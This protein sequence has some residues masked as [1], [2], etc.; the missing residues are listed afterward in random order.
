M[1]QNTLY[2]IFLKLDRLRVLIVGAGEVGYEKLSFMLKSSPDAQITV[3]AKEVL[4]PVQQL[5][6]ELQPEGLTVIEKPFEAEDVQGYGLVIAA[7]NFRALNEQVRAA[8]KANGALVN[9]ADTPELCDFYLGSIVTR[10][11]LKVAIST[12]GQSPTFAKRFRQWLEAALPDETEELLHN[13]NEFRRRLGGDFAEKVRQLNRLT[14][15]LLAE[16]EKGAP[17]K[18][19]AA[20][21]S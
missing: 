15:G 12:N 21:R 14:A 8:A 18:K 3:I 20:D 19:Q 4:A 11:N 6:D 5:I 17:A 16:K 10:G 7:T 2:P 1:A 9:V 13:L